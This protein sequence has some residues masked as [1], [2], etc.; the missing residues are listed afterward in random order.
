[1]LFWIGDE[2]LFIEDGITTYNEIRSAVEKMV[3]NM[4][5]DFMKKFYEKYNDMDSAVEGI[6]DY[7]YSY[8]L[9]VIEQ[10]V[11]FLNSLQ[12]KSQG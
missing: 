6:R 1:M 11:S 10:G 4:H 3:D 5:R 9:Q 7:S 12:I 8:L 2:Q